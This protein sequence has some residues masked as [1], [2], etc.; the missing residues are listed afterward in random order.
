MIYFVRYPETE[1]S[2]DSCE[3]RV[4]ASFRC[5]RVPTIQ[6]YQNEYTWQRNLWKITWRSALIL[7]IQ[8]WH[9]IL[10]DCFLPRYMWYCEEIR[11]LPIRIC[12]A[13]IFRYDA[14]RPCFVSFNCCLIFVEKKKQRCGRLYALGRLRW[15]HLT[16]K[17][18]CGI[19]RTCGILL[20]HLCT[21]QQ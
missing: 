7:W 9:C 6:P 5:M 8:V 4:V 16:R 19:F 12:K 17:A 15:R 2:T 1:T 21:I 14:W 11:N 18:T 3:C 13:T 20:R 10:I